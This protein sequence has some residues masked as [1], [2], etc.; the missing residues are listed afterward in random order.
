[1]RQSLAQFDPLGFTQH[2]HAFHEVLCGGC[3]NPHLRAL[4]ERE[5]SRLK[6]IRRTTFSLVPG[7]SQRSVLED[8]QLIRLIA[9]GASAAE[10]ERVAREHKLATL[11]AFEERA[12]VDVG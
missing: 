1:M 12:N 11:H 8:E 7:R 6:V 3:P 4:V 5:W 10:I 2:N 9:A